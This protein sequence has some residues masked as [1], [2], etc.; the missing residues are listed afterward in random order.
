MGY[1]RDA[2]GAVE[3]ERGI[4]SIDKKGRNEISAPPP[5]LPDRDWSLRS[6]VRPY[7]ACACCPGVRI[8][9]LAVHDAA[10]VGARAGSRQPRPEKRCRGLQVQSDLY[11]ARSRR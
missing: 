9:V 7:A 11:A 1:L 8:R 3:C 10:L 5:W 6:I 4:R 2:R